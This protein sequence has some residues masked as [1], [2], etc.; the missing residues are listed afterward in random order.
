MSSKHITM[1]MRPQPLHFVSAFLFCFF[2]YF[3][4]FRVSS[5]IL[6]SG[7]LARVC[8]ACRI[9]Y[10]GTPLHCLLFLLQYDIPPLS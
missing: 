8:C 3:F 1:A 6:V 5:N 10:E 9:Q 4:A 2:N 7:L